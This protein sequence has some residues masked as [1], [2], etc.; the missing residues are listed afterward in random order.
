MMPADLQIRALD[1]AEYAGKPFVVRY[2]TRGYYDVTADEDGFHLTF[3]AFDAPVEKGFEDRLFGDWLEDPVAYG[4][5]DGERLVG[6]IEGSPESWNRRY[7]ISNLCV[8]EEADRGKGVGRALMDVLL[9]EA[10]RSGTRMAV[11]E[12]QSCNVPA[13]AFYRKCGFRCIGLDLY[14]YTNRDPER[15]EVRLE[16]GLALRD[17]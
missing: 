14:A 7:R 9:A 13:I 12:T 16:M 8:P 1:R 5:F 4:A 2:A 15:G 17:E 3:R 10:K 11:L 6:F